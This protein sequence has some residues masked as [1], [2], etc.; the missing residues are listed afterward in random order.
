MLDD[1]LEV[2]FGG[3]A[4]GGKSD[5]LLMAALQYVSE[6]GYA[7][8]LFR[9]TYVDLSIEGGLIPRSHEWLH[10]TDAAW[11]GSEKKWRFPSGAVLGFG[12]MENENDY[13]N[14]KGLEAQYF[15]FDQLEQFA[16][17]PYQFMFSRLRRR[18]GSRVPSRMRSTANPPKPEEPGARWLRDY[19]VNAETKSKGV[20]FVPSFL[21]DNPSLDQAEYGANLARLS[22]Y[23]QAL[24]RDGNWWAK[25]PRQMFDP[26]WFK[27][28]DVA[29]IGLSH[30]R[31]WDLAATE[32]SMGNDPDRTAGALCGFDKD[33]IFWIVD[34]V[35]F[36]KE[37]LGVKQ[38]IRQ[39][40][41]LDGRAVRIRIEQEGGASGKLVVG[42]F[43]RELRG[44]P[45]TADRKTGS[46]VARAR[47]LANYAEAGNVRIVRA[48]WNR[49]L[50]EEFE[51]F[52]S[53]GH[54]DRVDAVSGAFAELA[55]R[56]S[57]LVVYRR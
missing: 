16:Q 12:H 3:A 8:Y 57:K 46:K 54:D 35:A 50:L 51:S 48:A 33:K 45:V 27:I 44:W 53:G 36:R 1:T 39:A 13:L 40:A 31:Y 15:G 14:Y 26:T 29:P 18:E 41:E 55:G 38:G 11:N 2:L 37:G 49:E 9:R 17:K 52:P 20:V 6:P 34:V 10:G 5:G 4:G 22:V 30:L 42:D 23:E 28:E 21:V 56:P 24:Y 32:E 19:F 25:P 43:I 47:P 7:A